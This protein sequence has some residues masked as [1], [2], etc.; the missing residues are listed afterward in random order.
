ML[1]IQIFFHRFSRV[2]PAD[3]IPETPTP[4]SKLMSPGIQA[5]PGLAWREI[6]FMTALIVWALAVLLTHLQFT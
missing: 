6:V 3:K 2:L 1:T 4:P 5:T